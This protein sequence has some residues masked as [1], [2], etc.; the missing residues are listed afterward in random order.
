MGQRPLVIAGDAAHLMPPFAGEGICAGLRDAAALGWR[1]DAILNR[2]LPKDGL[3]SYERERIADAQHYIQF[4]QDLGDIICITDEA[5]AA[6]R[7]TRMFAELASRKYEPI[8]GDLVKLG[9]GIWCTSAGELS[10]KGVVKYGETIDRFDQ[11]VGQGWIVLAIKQATDELLTQKQ[12]YKLALLS[13]SV[14]SVG[15]TGRNVTTKDYTYVTWLAET[16]AGL[17]IIRPDFYV[18]ATAKTPKNLRVRF[19]RIMSLLG[20]LNLG[21]IGANI[22]K[23]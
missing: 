10:P 21:S 17:A 2:T 13:G 12:L 6:S 19:D 11:A 18:A 5:A 4:S 15:A 7:D 3:H 20:I 23:T 16:G 1:L 9:D 8:T 14:L 22:A